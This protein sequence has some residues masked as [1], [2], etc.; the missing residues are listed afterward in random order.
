MNINC[1]ISLGELVDKISILKIKL[2]KITDTE[3]LKH[4]Q[5]E[6]ETL[7]KTLAS[8][9]LD[10][11][12]YHLNQMIDVNQKL[13]KIEDDIRDLERDKDFGEAFIELARAVYITNDERFRRKNTINTTYKSGLVE[14][15][16]YKDY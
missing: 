1:E 6:E 10:N 5:R 13:W 7:S 9:K 12:D 14:V 3:K 11:I 16:S 2:E 8:L 4:V 15:K